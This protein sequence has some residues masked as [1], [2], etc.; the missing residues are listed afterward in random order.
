LFD[1]AYI[2]RIILEK[3]LHR[4]HGLYKVVLY[5]TIA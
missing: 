2:L 3:L 1:A 4:C 5:L